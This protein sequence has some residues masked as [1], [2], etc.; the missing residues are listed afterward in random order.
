MPKSMQTR[1]EEALKSSD[2]DS[3]KYYLDTLAT[4]WKDYADGLRRSATLMVVLIVVF[5]L[6]LKGIVRQANVGPFVISGTRAIEPFVPTGIAYFYYDSLNCAMNFENIAE[7]Y[8]FTFRIWNRMAEF[9]DLDVI[10]Q[11][12]TPPFFPA[13]RAITSD[14]SDSGRAAYHVRLVTL[15]MLGILSPILFEVY[16]FG[17]LY[18]LLHASSILLWVNVSLTLLQ[19]A[20]IIWQLVI[21]SSE[22]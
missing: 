22:D 8:R 21:F 9:N 10:A 19:L 18:R 20:A 13:G 5:E 12:R 11:P 16:A 2:K 17:Q 1:I 7:A 15:A 14:L 3:V 6:L 4:V